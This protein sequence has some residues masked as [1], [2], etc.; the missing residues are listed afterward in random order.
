LGSDAL[1][2]GAQDFKNRSTSSDEYDYD[3]NGNMIKDLNKDVVTMSWN[4]LNL[5]DTIQLKGGHMESFIYD[6]TGQ[7][8]GIQTNELE[9]EE[10]LHQTN[11]TNR[12]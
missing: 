9:R 6:A 10:L 4:S 2:T 3:Q 5:P 1:Y 12:Q 8:W 7:N 11:Y